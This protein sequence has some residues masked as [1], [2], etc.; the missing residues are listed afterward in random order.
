MH[1]QTE[2]QTGAPAGLCT[3][4]TAHGKPGMTLMANMGSEA[5]A[6]TSTRVRRPPS[7]GM[8]PLWSRSRPRPRLTRARRRLPSSS[9]ASSW[10]W[11][12]SSPWPRLAPARIGV[13]SAAVGVLADNASMRTELKTATDL[14]DDL[15]IQRSVLS[16]TQRIDRIATQSYGMVLATGTEQ[17]M[18]RRRATTRPAA[19]TP[20]PPTWPSRARATLPPRRAPSSAPRRS[21]ASSATPSRPRATAPPPVLMQPMWTR[22]P[23]GPRSRQVA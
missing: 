21:P 2:P 9:P 15:R 23:K 1:G 14:A 10:P 16:S 11:A 8:P 13:Y 12:S 17:M 20:P 22:S 7:T 5:A 3:Q 19:M 18:H 4:R 6:S